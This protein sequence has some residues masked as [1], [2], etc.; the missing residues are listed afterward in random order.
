MK[1]T[2]LIHIYL[3]IP[4]HNTATFV[5]ITWHQKEPLGCAVYSHCPTNDSYNKCIPCCCLP[6]SY[7]TKPSDILQRVIKSQRVCISFGRNKS[8]Y[9]FSPKSLWLNLQT[10][11]I[12]N[13]AK[14]LSVRLR[15]NWLW[16]WVQLQSLKLQILCLLW[17][18]SSLTF[19]QLWS[20]DYLWKIILFGFL[21][22]W[23]FLWYLKKLPLVNTEWTLLLFLFTW[24]L[25]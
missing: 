23:G 6:C 19:R 20:V 13:L 5:S 12:Y 16:V 2:K 15:T 25:T 24:W 11:Q 17:V 7:V 4:I 3:W 8:W 1:G 9:L 10:W 18:R 14:W 21:Y 22:F